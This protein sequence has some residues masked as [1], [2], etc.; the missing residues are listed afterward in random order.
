[1]SMLFPS[2][3]F[4]RLKEHLIL[5]ECALKTVK[6]R[7][8]ILLK[9]FENFQS[10]NPIEHVKER[11]KSS[12]SIADKL[13]R[14]GFEMTAENAREHLTDIAGVRIICSYAR[15]ILNIA[16]VIKRQEDIT[17][18]SERDYITKPKP[19]G[20]RSY[21]LI[22][23]VPFYL[24]GTL[25]T[26]PVEV[27]I[28]TSAMDFWAS[29]EHKVKYKYNGKMPAHLSQELIDCAVQIAELDDRMYN[30]Q[31]VI[32]LAYSHNSAQM[33]ERTFNSR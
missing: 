23:D 8:D 26:L 4:V 27:Q 33:M 20:Y 9:D 24:T 7:I 2:G 16:T 31:D 19:S 30:V 28:R 13:Y 12:E 14:R 18:R 1:M 5:Y 11:I 10:Y 6:T 3:E 25:E 22:L 21:H 29:L 15:D 17:V 32:D